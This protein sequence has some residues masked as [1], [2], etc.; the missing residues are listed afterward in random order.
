MEEAELRQEQS[1]DWARGQWGV[2]E[3]GWTRL[4]EAGP[5]E[6]TPHTSQL[7]EDENKRQ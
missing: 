4:K 6:S 7:S 2:A 5:E 3:A 1:C